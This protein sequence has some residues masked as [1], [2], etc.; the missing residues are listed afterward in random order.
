[1][2]I[3]CLEITSLNLSQGELKTLLKRYRLQPQKASLPGSSDDLQSKRS[4]LL[5]DLKR[6]SGQIKPEDAK[7]F[8]TISDKLGDEDVKMNL[9]VDDDARFTIM[10]T[11]EANAQY[12]DLPENWQQ[13]ETEWSHRELAR[14]ITLL[15]GGKSN[16]HISVEDELRAYDLKIDTPKMKLDNILGEQEVMGGV[17]R[18]FK[19]RNIKE[20]NS[21][22]QQKDMN[23]L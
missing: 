8:Q 17:M 1:M 18:I 6:L 11:L 5:N 7:E 10:S 23:I 14:V 15:W 20:Y 12:S 4:R 22:V 2:T 13:W 3:F 9:L 21:E 16:T 19:R